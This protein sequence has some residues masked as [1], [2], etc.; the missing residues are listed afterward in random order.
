MQP[1]VPDESYL[2]LPAEITPELARAFPGKMNRLLQVQLLGRSLSD[3]DAALNLL[4]DLATELVPCDRALLLWADEADG[5]QR[6]KGMRG[7]LDPAAREAV[8]E[9]LGT[10]GPRRSGRPFMLSRTEDP[11]HSS[12]AT[13]QKLEARCLLSVP[14][15]VGEAVHGTIMLARATGADFEMEEAHLLRVF[16]LA[17]DG[18]LEGLVQEHR[19]PDLSYLDRLTGLFNRRYFEQQLEREV[20]RARRHGEAVSV[21][22]LRV[23]SLAA[24]QHE[25]GHADADALLQQ[26]ARAMRRVVR[27]SDTLSRIAED[28]FAAILPGTPKANLSIVAQRT[29]QALEHPTANGAGETAGAEAEFSLCAVNYPED[30]FSPESVLDASRE[31]LERAKTLPGKHYYYQFPSP[32]PQGGDDAILDTARAGIMREPVHEPSGLLRLFTRLA[33]DAVPADRVSVM[34]R[35]GED[36]VI[37]VAVGFEGQDEIVRTTRVPLTRKTVSSW[38][39][40]TRKPL[41]VAGPD[42]YADLPLNGAGTYRGDSFFSYPLLHEGELVG[43]IH[44]SNR[45]DGQPFTEADVERFAPVATFLSQY[46]VLSRGFDRVQEDFLNQSLFGLVDL[47]ESQVPGMAGHSVHVAHLARSI[48]RSLG[49]TE[50]TAQALWVTARLHNL[51]KV[52]YR[53]PILAEPRALSARE[54]ALTQ[55]HTLLSWKFLEGLPLRSVDREAILYHHEREDGSGYLHKT[56]DDVPLNAKI[57]AVADVYQ[58]LVSERP[59]RPAL[60]PQEALHYM[61]ANRGVL[62]DGRVVEA[63][64]GEVG[65]H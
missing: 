31:G 39:A 59:Y 3:C 44:F 20:D 60:P 64:R 36:L 24:R 65:S 51:G 5:T 4:L 55:R 19:G 28:E 35:D 14:V 7:S 11:T 10:E 53:T 45:S 2:S 41:L 40:Q 47:M 49:C 18:I 32:A 8:E 26:V 1:T 50:E 52:S 17:F 27:K 33:L 37:Q 25:R 21:V 54:R 34:I 38:V 43:L 16:T 48:A 29:F 42:Q 62:F 58:A 9:L 30:A 12:G 57:L 63:L 15:Y 22:T 61:E 56:G 6:V 46:V 13:L 23:E